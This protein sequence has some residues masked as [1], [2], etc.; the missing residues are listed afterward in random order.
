[1][2]DGTTLGW[3]AEKHFA[4]SPNTDFLFGPDAIS[5][6]PEHLHSLFNGTPAT[7]Q[8]TDDTRRCFS[9][10]SILFIGHS[11]VLGV[12]SEVCKIINFSHP[13]ITCNRMSFNTWK[14]SD[15]VQPWG[16]DQVGYLGIDELLTP[17]EKAKFLAQEQ[18]SKQQAQAAG[19]PAPPI[20]RPSLWWRSSMD[21]YLTTD[22]SLRRVRSWN[23]A[24]MVKKTGDTRYQ[25]ILA[26]TGLWDLHFRNTAPREMFERTRDS[27]LRLSNWLAIPQQRPPKEEGGSTFDPSMLVVML[28]HYHRKPSWPSRVPCT[29]ED[30]VMA[31]RHAIE[32]AAADAAETLRYGERGLTVQIRLLDVYNFT[33]DIQHEKAFKADGHHLAKGVV[34]DI[35]RA[36]LH[37]HV[38]GCS[39]S[40]VRI[41]DHLASQ[42]IVRVPR[43]ERQLGINRDDLDA[44]LWPD[45]PSCETHRMTTLSAFHTSAMHNSLRPGW[46]AQWESFRGRFANY[47]VSAH[48]P[49]NRILRAQCIYYTCKPDPDDALPRGPRES[50]AS[51]EASKACLRNVGL[52]ENLTTWD[53]PVVD[54]DRAGRQL[55]SSK[56]G[57]TIPPCYCVSPASLVPP[58][59]QKF[60]QLRGIDVVQPRITSFCTNMLK[61]MLT[62]FTSRTEWALTR[63]ADTPVT[64]VV[65]ALEQELQKL[66][67][68]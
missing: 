15:G 10:K 31:Y 57:M 32:L 46:D 22:G 47:L 54:A 51:A 4:V 67:P 24:T 66:D 64:D 61:E 37:S 48:R 53:P 58:V 29:T 27:L 28:P 60:E 9:G 18:T 45:R 13:E 52:T 55:L 21:P 62:F 34:Q 44:I 49:E 17:K 26:G 5:D 12:G 56:D 65:E 38:V 36:F 11:H 30:R 14:S 16:F 68:Q 8:E 25:L 20:A 23:P 19:L 59:Q 6:A 40:E 42:A 35:A 63:C 1:M 2:L 50:V 43:N 39:S 7:H 3:D 33:K 41:S